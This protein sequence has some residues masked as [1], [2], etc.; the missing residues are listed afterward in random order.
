MAH[1]WRGALPSPAEPSART[2][3]RPTPPRGGM[4]RGGGEMKSNQAAGPPDPVEDRKVHSSLSRPTTNFPAPPRPASARLP[5]NHSMA[6]LAPRQLACG[7]RGPR[8]AAASALQCIQSVP[9]GVQRGL[10][11]AGQPCRELGHRCADSAASLA[12]WPGREARD[13]LVCPGLVQL[14][15]GEKRRATPPARR[16]CCQAGPCTAW[17]GPRPRPR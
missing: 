10:R 15:V 4:G 8:P 16:P 9:R 3:A 11:G 1:L 14:S 2:P 12:H 7:M 13:A 6:F 5:L 17:S